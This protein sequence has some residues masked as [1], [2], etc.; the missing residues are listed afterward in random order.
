MPKLTQFKA[1]LF[2]MDGTL[3][4]FQRVVTPE[5]RAAL[6]QLEKA[7]FTCGLC[8]GKHFGKL[9]QEHLTDVFPPTTIH[10]LTGGAQVVE[11]TGK[12]LWQKTL[13]PQIARTVMDLAE[14][15]QLA[16]LIKHD[17]FMY[18]NQ[19][20]FD[21]VRHRRDGIEQIMKPVSDPEAYHNLLTVVL[22]EPPASAIEEL[23]RLPDVTVKSNATTGGTYVDVTAKG[24][25]KAAGL[26]HWC[27]LTNISPEQIIGFGDSDNDYEFLRAVGYAVAMGNATPAIASIADKM[28]GHVNDNGLPI[29]LQ[30]ILATGEL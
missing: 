24:I 10:I 2:D 7:G 14:K 20:A 11:G 4:N 19:A 26:T 23:K 29:Y 28:I 22:I 27:E 16:C 1:A 9:E 5:T 8:T 3:S 13:S 25:T 6:R 21:R 12:V 18:A 17:H 15:E 30:S